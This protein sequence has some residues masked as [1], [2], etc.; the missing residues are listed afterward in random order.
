[1]YRWGESSDSDP[2]RSYLSAQSPALARLHLASH[3]NIVILEVEQVFY[4]PWT[5]PCSTKSTW[6]FN[7]RRVIHNVKNV[8][9][10]PTR[11]SWLNLTRRAGHKRNAS[12]LMLGFKGTM[13]TDIDTDDWLITLHQIPILESSWPPVCSIS[14]SMVHQLVSIT[15][16][17]TIVHAVMANKYLWPLVDF[18]IFLC[19]S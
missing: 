19:R 14:W 10:V 3:G 9:R 15:S 12:W 16:T 1:M 6:K 13:L 2:C 18:I 11:L 5:L 7:F 17:F 4:N 8:T